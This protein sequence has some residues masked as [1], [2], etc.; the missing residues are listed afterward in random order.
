MKTFL[1]TALILFLSYQMTIGQISYDNRLYERKVEKYTK[2]KRTGTTLGIAGGALTVVG[3]ILMSNANWHTDTN[4]Y[5]QTQTT[6]DDP[7]GVLGLVSVLVGVPMAGTGV[8]L[9]IIGGKKQRHY[10]RKLDNL[11]AGYFQR[12]GAHGITLRIKI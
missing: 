2:L 10:Q 6:T 7:Q 8:V 9:G 4:A 5:G 3:V 12:H 11:S 1:L